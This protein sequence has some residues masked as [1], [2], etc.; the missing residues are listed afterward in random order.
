MKNHYQILELE[1]FA[2]FE[3]VRVAYLSL[4]K[5]N[6]PDLFSTEMKKLNATRKMQQL[7]ESYGVLKD[8]YEKTLYDK[9]LLN[10]LKLNQINDIGKFK[11]T[12]Y[13]KYRDIP[14]L[15]I[16]EIII[17]ILVIIEPFLLPLILSKES[18][19]RIL[20]IWIPA[21]YRFYGISSS[22]KDIL[23][24]ICFI[25]I[26]LAYSFFIHN[27]LILISISIII[28]MYVYIVLIII[29]PIDAAIE[30]FQHTINAK[31]MPISDVIFLLIQ[32][33]ILISLPVFIWKYDKTLF[34]NIGVLIYAIYFCWGGVII[35]EISASII[36][37]IFYRDVMNTYTKFS[38]DLIKIRDNLRV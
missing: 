25:P 17:G 31:T 1:N 18:Y 6:H 32:L 38:R 26:S 20:F 37:I 9:Q 3:Q 11:S 13:S 15:N 4:A 12:L 16:A 24:L 35:G 36:R 29:N 2:P 33:V 23:Y 10:E 34:N 30:A 19:D 8:P 7:N 21:N 14:W 22:I 27:M 5:K 28:E